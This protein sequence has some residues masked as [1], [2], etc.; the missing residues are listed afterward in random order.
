ML[1][2]RAVSA[3]CAGVLA[4]LASALR[5]GQSCLVECD[6]DLTLFLYADLRER[7]SAAELSCSY[8][9]GRPG[10]E[11]GVPADAPVLPAMLRQLRAAV[12]GAAERR[13]V[14]VPHLDVLAASAAGL[15]AEARE[16]IPLLYEL[17]GQVWLG[18]RDPTLPLLPV[19]EKRF[20]ARFLVP[21]P[22]DAGG[23]TPPSFAQAGSD[24]AA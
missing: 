23:F 9:D 6:K 15:S 18:F 20:A 11:S 2:Q 17:P 19:V 3:S 13:V 12:R 10:P 4:E 16:V 24:P 21:R 22:V 1:S 14:V 7:L 8:V 5:A